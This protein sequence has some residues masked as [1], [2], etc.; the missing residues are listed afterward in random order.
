MPTSVVYNSGLGRWE[1]TF[2]VTGFSGFFGTTGNSVLP[3]SWLNLNASLND[4]QQAQVNWQVTETNVAGYSI[5]KSTDGISF[6]GIGNTVSKGD[7]TNSY[8][9][10]DLSASQAGVAFYRIRQT[11][12]DGG[13]G[14]SAIIDLSA[15]GHQLFYI[16]PNPAKNILYVTTSGMTGDVQVVDI[17]GQILVNVPITGDK[18]SIDINRLATGTYYCRASGRSILFVKK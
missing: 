18:T 15:A 7:G 13:F 16:Y 12:K 2:N 1:A 4:R 3:V 9:F 17:V 10:I 6:S 5:E 14:Y 8:S 11:D